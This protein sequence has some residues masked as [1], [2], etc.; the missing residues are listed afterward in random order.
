MGKL[1]SIPP[2][3]KRYLEL[4]FHPNWLMLKNELETLAK[5][6]IKIQVTLTGV[7]A[8]LSLHISK[9]D[10]DN[11]TTRFTIVGL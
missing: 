9:G 2:A 3:V 1:T 10:P 8:K 5:S 4:Q 11:S 6:I 7:Q